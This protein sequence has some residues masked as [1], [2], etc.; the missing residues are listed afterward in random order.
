MLVAGLVLLPVSVFL[1]EAVLWFGRNALDAHDA[2][3]DLEAARGWARTARRIA[4][5]S[6][7]LL[8]FAFLFS[9][10]AAEETSARL[11]VLLF[12]LL[13][14]LGAGALSGVT[15]RSPLGSA[16]RAVAR[17]LTGIGSALRHVLLAWGRLPG[18]DEPIEAL[19][20]VRELEHESGWLFGLPAEDDPGRV[21]ATL[22]EFGEARAE[23]VMVP[24]EEVVG[25]PAGASRAEILRV[26][27][28]ERHSR[29]PVYRDSLDRV[30]GVLHVF[31]LLSA[32]PDADAASLA[33]KPFLTHA[34]K[35]VSALL[36]ELQVTYNQMA[37]VVDEYGGTAGLVTVE[38]LLE[39]LVGEIEDEHDEEEIPVRRLEAG[40]FWV[41][42]TMRIEEVNVA[43]ELD[44][45]EG[46]YD[47]LAGLVLERL[48]RVPRPGERIRENGVWLEVVGAEPHRIHAVKVIILD[49]AEASRRG[50]EVR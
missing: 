7:L 37:V 15:W 32:P 11:A 50:P 16:G 10:F 47:T 35:S 5:V 30:V 3:D 12:G 28:T 41:E 14:S 31:D 44:L 29:Y 27:E 8:G 42:G 46:E 49:R 39:E 2:E 34:T 38:D 48:E 33:R 24:R 26:V 36:R 22:H 9:F 19:D 43:L 18:P 6:R 40:V 25:I 45:P 21:L 23:E 13:W 17:P 1:D 20:A 4:L